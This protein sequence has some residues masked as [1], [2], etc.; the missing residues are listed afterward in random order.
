MDSAALVS[1]ALR[2]NARYLEEV[3]LGWGL[4]PWAEAALRGGQVSRTV[5]LEEEPALEPVLAFI[6]ALVAEPA[7]AIG[8]VIFPRAD[9]SAR[10][11]D[12]FAERVRRAD[13]ARRRSEPG[14]PPFFVAAFHPLGAGDFTSAPEMVSFVRRSPDPM[15]Q[16]VRSALVARLGSEVSADVGRWN[17]AHV[18]SK[19]AP[20]LD[21]LLRDIRRD[22]DASYS[23]LRGG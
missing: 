6:D 7:T 10:E 20:V 18:T 3:V 4:C 22:R 12:S 14:P 8:L 2:L 16:L 5:A 9:G 19:G 13:R 17:F 21:A 23:A 15:L 1:E 11:F